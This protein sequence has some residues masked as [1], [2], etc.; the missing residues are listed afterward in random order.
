MPA[1]GTKVQQSSSF[2]GFYSFDDRQAQLLQPQRQVF[3][4]FHPTASCCTTAVHRQ[5]SKE[6]CGV[7]AAYLCTSRLEPGNFILRDVAGLQPPLLAPG[8]IWTL[9]GRDNDVTVLLDDSPYG[10]GARHV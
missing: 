6:G 4:F 7:V 1:H 2:S 8:S 5:V 9:R 3:L 10:H